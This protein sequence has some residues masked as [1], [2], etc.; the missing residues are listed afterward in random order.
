MTKILKWGHIKR[1]RRKKFTCTYCGCEWLATADVC[2]RITTPEYSIASKG[3][4]A[5]YYTECPRCGE[6]T[7]LLEFKK[8]RGV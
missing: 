8:K 7:V 3:I 2:R 5:Y 6:T 4:T 1:F